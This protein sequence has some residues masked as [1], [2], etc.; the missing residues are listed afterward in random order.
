MFPVYIDSAR[1]I[2]PVRTTAIQDEGAEGVG[3][4]SLTSD[5][6]CVYSEGSV[7]LIC[8]GSQVST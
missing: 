7:Q 3:P 4:L 1:G 8:K 2:L 5:Y 6:H